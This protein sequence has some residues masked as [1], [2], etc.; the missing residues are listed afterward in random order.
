SGC[1]AEKRFRAYLYHRLAVLKL[2]VPPLRR[3]RDDI[4]L[5][6][7]HF[8]SLVH[9]GT[10]AEQ[11]LTPSVLASFALYGWPGNV[12]ELRNAIERLVLL[13]HSGEGAF[14]GAL[15]PTLDYHDARGNAVDAFEQEY[16]QALLRANGGVVAHAATRAGIAREL[17]HRLL[18]KHQFGV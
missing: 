2:V 13:G 7:Q 17:F 10:P 6:A 1:V 11:V 14:L 18:R 4:P 15:A 3:R 8:V 16:C 9:P 5:L 12:R